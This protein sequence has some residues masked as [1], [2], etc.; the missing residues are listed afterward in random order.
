MT[1]KLQKIIFII[2]GLLL[3]F[4]AYVFLVKK[5][6][7]AE[8]LITDDLA[9]SDT[10]ILGDRITQ[11]LLRIE[12]IKLDKSIFTNEVYRSL[13]DRSIPIEPEPVGRNNPF[14]PIGD[15]SALSLQRLNQTTT[16]TTTSV[17]TSTGQ[18]VNRTTN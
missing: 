17:A 5:D 4:L 8:S 10:D 1:P 15:I 7:E 11:A 16:S 18:S 9:S 12:Q 13:Q 6:P 14:A 3:I 2:L